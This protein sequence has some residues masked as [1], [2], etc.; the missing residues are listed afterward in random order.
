MMDA[1][2]LMQALAQLSDAEWTQLKCGED[3]RRNATEQRCIRDLSAKLRE[4]HHR[5][6]PA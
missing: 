3:R 4:L 6:G 5:R 2:Q 1:K